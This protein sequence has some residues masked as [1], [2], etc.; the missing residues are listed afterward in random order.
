[1]WSCL[2]NLVSEL[3]HLDRFRD[4]TIGETSQN[5]R[6]KMEIRKAK[7]EERAS[8][9]ALI[10]RSKAHWGYDDA[11]M[12]ACRDELSMDAERLLSDNFRVLQHHGKVVGTVEL[13]VE[14]PKAH[15]HKLFI[16]PD[17][18]GSGA[19]RILYEW[20]LAR[21][22]SFNATAMLID[23]DPDA[24]GFY[25]YMGARV[26]GQVPSGSIEGRFLPLLQHDLT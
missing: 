21:A 14:G 22:R 23:A 17:L 19:G 26:I 7:T 13:A 3:C 2:C 9:N 24:C 15:L 8:I 12:D 4:V 5:Q 6:Y 11:F 10:L 18:I 16:D 25:E 20:A 1:M